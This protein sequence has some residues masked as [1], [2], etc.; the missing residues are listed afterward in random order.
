MLHY[1]TVHTIKSNFYSRI[2]FVAFFPCRLHFDL[3]SHFRRE[4]RKRKM[5]KQM[6]ENGEGKEK[7]G[8]LI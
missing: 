2:K 7:R 8:I 1:F 6:V 3:G 5:G 4:G